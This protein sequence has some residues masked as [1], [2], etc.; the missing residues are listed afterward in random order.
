M[1]LTPL[2]VMDRTMV[3]I[4]LMCS[5][6]FYSEWEACQCCSSGRGPAAAARATICCLPSWLCPVPHRPRQPTRILAQASCV[7]S[8]P[9]RSLINMEPRYC[10]SE[11]WA[12]S[13]VRVTT[14][15]PPSRP[16]PYPMTPLPAMPDG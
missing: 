5:V 16:G 2:Y 6:D 15:G 9:R 7:D 8:V 4:F 10:G 1:N 14:L 3:G 12:C 11:Q 13:A